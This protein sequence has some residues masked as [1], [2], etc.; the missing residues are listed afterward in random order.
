VSFGLGAS[1]QVMAIPLLGE[2]SLVSNGD[3]A[4]AEGF[5]LRRARLGVQG[6][7]AE[8]LGMEL[9]LDALDGEEGVHTAKVNWKIHDALR[10]ALGTGKV[11]YARMAMDSSSRLRFVD[12]PVGT[13]ELTPGHRLGFTLEGRCLD[14]ALNYIAGVYN[15]S[16]GLGLGNPNE[17]ILYGGRLETAPLGAP[18]DLFPTEW[19]VVLGGGAIYEDGPTTNT[20]AYSG[21]I[22]IEGPWF[23]VRGE[24]LWDARTPEKEPTLPAGS[25]AETEN[26]V[27][28]AEAA[29]FVWPESVEIAVR[30]ER[31]DINKDTELFGDQ[32]I[33]TGGVNWYVRGHHLKVQA[34]YLHRDELG[35]IE[36]DND[37]VIL[38]VLGAL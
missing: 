35:A 22:H 9:V 8:N 21:D 1:I 5:R 15:G 3:P 23:R 6:M 18:A 38:S 4:N 14:G 7:W 12:R 33:L 17:G 34:H 20:L 11:P 24:Y 10:L 29:V 30:W 13:G 16:E 32:Q 26:E 31:V 25:V 19:R 37:A 28:L 2:D 36:L 27:I